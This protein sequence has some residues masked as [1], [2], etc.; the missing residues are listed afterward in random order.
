MVGSGRLFRA[1]FGTLL[2]VG[3][4]WFLTVGILANHASK[5]STITVRSTEIFKYWKLIGREKRVVHW[6][7]DLNYVSRRRVPNG[8]DPIH[9]RY[10]YVLSLLSIKYA[11][12]TASKACS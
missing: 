11:S 8:P 3:V 7:S 5:T 6:A 12:C 4:I 10:I 9:N 1:L 2:F